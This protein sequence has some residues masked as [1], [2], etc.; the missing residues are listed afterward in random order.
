M[1][2]QPPGSTNIEPIL[3][4][5]RGNNFLVST[6]FLESGDFFR[7]RTL[8]L[9]YTFDQKLLSNVGI[10]KAK[11]Y[12]SGQN[13]KTWSRVTGYS[14][15]PLI[16]SMLGWRCRQWRIPRAGNLF[17]WYQLNFLKLNISYMK[18]FTKISRNT[19][20]AIVAGCIGVV[21]VYWL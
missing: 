1:R 20:P 11:I 6:Y 12:L 9:G 10:Q 15:E 7:I 2:G 5:T 4:N 16:G 21:I 18:Y 3:D 13:I 19:Y 8:Q 17:I 14:P